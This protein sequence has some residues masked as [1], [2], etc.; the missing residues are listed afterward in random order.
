MPAASSV[1]SP[2]VRP[3]PHLA[4]ATLEGIAHQVTDLV[5][6]MAEDLGKPLGKLRVDGGAAKNDLLLT[7]QAR[8][9]ALTIERPIDLETT[10][11]GAAMLA[12][13]GAGLFDDKSAAATMSPLERAFAPTDAERDEARAGWR[14]AIKRARG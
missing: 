2:E 10:A 8:F 12:A 14:A 5:E 1:A 9:A 11:R 3:S 6:A 13:V 4:R 7:D